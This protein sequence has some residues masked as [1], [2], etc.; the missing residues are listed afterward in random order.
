MEK[1][2]KQITE[3][4]LSQQT[5]SCTESHKQQENLVHVLSEEKDNSFKT[6]LSSNIEKGLF[7][8]EF[9][10]KENSRI[11]VEP[12]NTRIHGIQLL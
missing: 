8:D 1:R 4:K 5:A 7:V 9:L 2:Q 3:L 10:L 11:P 6:L 12:A